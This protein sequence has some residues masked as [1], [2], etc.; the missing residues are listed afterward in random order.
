MGLVH[1]WARVASSAP[2]LANFFTQTP[3]L[4]RLGKALGGIAP[5]RRLPRFAAETFR[6][7]P[8][9]IR[10]VLMDLTMP[11]MGGEA[12][13]AELRRIR[14]DV[15]IVLSSGY[16]LQAQAGR[17]AGIGASMF[18]QKPYRM[19]ELAAAV[20]EALSA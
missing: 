8:G 9:S 10:L 16:A 19:A 2:A 17:L 12:A 11:R 15:P 1:R 3:G 18:V 5:E 7:N 13:V 4:S 14:S 6:A 20:R